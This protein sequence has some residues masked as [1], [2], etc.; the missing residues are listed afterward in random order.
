MLAGITAC[1]PQKKAARHVR[2]A[3][4]LCPELVQVTVRHIDTVL[5]APGFGDVTT[6]PLEK[7]M[8][9]DTLYSATDHGTFVVNIIPDDSTLRVGFI[10]APQPVHYRDTLR[11]EQVVLDETLINGKRIS[12][13]GI[14]A[15]CLV[16]VLL[17][18]IL[19]VWLMKRK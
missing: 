1:S 2:K 10:A 4:E 16:G 5:T 7:V 11:Y 18:V 9:G 6:I 13:G 15:L 12:T 8:S 17:G 14:F 19:T 3:V